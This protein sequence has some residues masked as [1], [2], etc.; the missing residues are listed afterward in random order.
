MP[1]KPVD[2]SSF[3]EGYSRAS[4][5]SP[6][7]RTTLQSALKPYKLTLASAKG[8]SDFA[9]RRLAAATVVKKFRQNKYPGATKYDQA[10]PERFRQ[11]GMRVLF[12]ARVKKNKAIADA[13][14]AARVK[15]GL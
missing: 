6:V 13:A 7:P 5:Y 11:Y 12:N 14:Y 4:G 9:L 10:T 3:Y 1:N 2:E 8:K 15:R